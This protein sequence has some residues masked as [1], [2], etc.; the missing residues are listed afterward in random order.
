MK[1]PKTQL[2]PIEAI[3]E[4]DTIARCVN[5]PEVVMSRG[6]NGTSNLSS[7]CR[8]AGKGQFTASIQSYGDAFYY[9]DTIWEALDGLLFKVRLLMRGV[10]DRKIQEALND[11]VS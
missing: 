5:S 10:A 1:M 7:S 4:L 8:L 11:V 9:A 6:M 2:T 3:R